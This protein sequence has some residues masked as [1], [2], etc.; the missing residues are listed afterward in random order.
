MTDTSAD[1]GITA[2]NE[3]NYTNYLNGWIWGTGRVNIGDA[4]GDGKLD[5]AFVAG[6][7]LYTI[8]TTAP[9]TNLIDL[10]AQP[11]TINDS[12]SGVLTVTIYDFDNDG[13]PEMVYR[14]SQEV[15]V[16]D[17]ATGTTKLWAS[18]CQSHT[19]TEGPIIADMNGDGAT[20]IGV[21][22]NKSNSF[23]INDPIQQQALGEIRMYFSTGNEWLPTRQV[24]NQPG[25]HVT[26][27]NDDLTLPF[28]QLDGSMI[29]NP[30]PCA[31]GLPGPQTPL[32]IFLNQVPFLSADGCPVFPAP[33]LEF[34][35][36]DP[37]NLP[38]PPGDP[39]NF[40]AVVVT[41]PICGNLDIDVSFNFA[42][43]G[44]L[45][46]SDAIPVS[47]FQGDPTDPSITSDSL[48][49][50]TII[51]VT[52]LQVGD[53]ITTAPVTFNGP[54]TPFRLYIVLNNNGSILP[55]NPNGSVTNEC[56]IDNN[57]YDV[58]VTPSPFSAAIQ[59]IK[60]NN[61]CVAADPNVGELR[62]RIYKGPQ[63]AAN[64]VVDYSD[65]AFQ[66]YYGTGTTNPVPANLGGKNYNL[67]AMPEGDYTLVVTNT[68]KGCSTLPVSSTI[69]LNITLPAVVVNVLSH[70]NSV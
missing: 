37:E 64:E 70:Q 43:T 67:T 27:I 52:N 21:T 42:N 13:K 19:Y 53:T 30:G 54:G 65:Y 23:N 59:K 46:I 36:D 17:G 57:I 68:S 63:V 5:L 66:W 56:R 38:Y 15:V 22:C 26:N 10:W 29:F 34:V 39:R 61:K 62:A 1:L 32:N 20:D 2:G 3:P 18:P 40:P 44:D 11:R 14:D 25:Y 60:D 9:G 55:I 31:N 47:F 49:F 58:L 69:L 12:R 33:D 7:Q 28:P 41:P 4:N 35:G 16:I 8:T 51:T 48:L 6:N 24:W 45:P 50:S